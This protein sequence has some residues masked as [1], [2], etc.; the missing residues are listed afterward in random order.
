MDG[1]KRFQ[2]VV[3]WVMAGCFLL[4][5]S[6]V[7][8][9]QQTAG[10]EASKDRTAQADSKKQPKKSHQ[11]GDPFSAEG[12]RKADSGEGMFSGLLKLG[13]QISSALPGQDDQ[14][15]SEKPSK[16]AG[17]SRSDPFSG[18]GGGAGVFSGL[19]KIGDRLSSAG[20]P[21]DSKKEERTILAHKGAPKKPDTG[22]APD[23]PSAEETVQ[24]SDFKIEETVA[25]SDIHYYLPLYTEVTSCL[26]RGQ[27]TAA[28]AVLSEGSADFKDRNRLLFLLENG[29]V[30]LYAAQYGASLQA[31]TE[32]ER[33]DEELYTKS[34]SLQATTF[35]VN[36]L[37][38]PYRGEDYESVMINLFLALA[39]L[40]EKNLD[41]AL[42]EARKVDS[43]LSAI[44]ASYPEDRK[45]AYREDA[46]VR[47]LMGILYQSDPTS[48]NLNDAFVSYRKALEIYE[49][50][51]AKN[52]GTPV[53]ELLKKQVL[54][55]SEWA[56]ESELAEARKRVG[57]LPYV[58][59]KEAEKQA[60][61]T[62]IHFNGKS[63]S[64]VERS[65]VCPLPDGHIIKVA[66]PKYVN[67]LY[68]VDRAR[69]TAH[70]VG[71]KQTLTSDTELGEP[72]AHI[73][74]LNLENRKG[75]IMTKAITRAMAK[76][77]ATKV[78]Q[79][80][81]EQAWG[82]M[83]GLLV[84]ALGDAYIII[85]EQADLRGW[86]TLPA[87]IRLTQLHL[88]PGTYGLEA[89]CYDKKGSQVEKVPLG[90][91]TLKQ[92]EKRFFFVSTTL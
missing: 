90:T 5:M 9:Q 11:R 92:G 23:S 72:I 58:S 69:I 66:F 44:N 38:A 8:T 43:K 48:A 45:N 68:R 73:A 53:P 59:L 20:S 71:R 46:F 63:P 76:Y 85:S 15:A 91:V 16:R 36:D 34:L 57:S 52:Y 2:S 6:C 56:G 17:A 26:D 12:A 88:P 1:F 35:I 50:D 60:T 25:S 33:L 24:L 80:Q 64:K 39:Y 86:V 65:I 41:G 77:A 42:V 3:A 61:V 82:Y 30:N 78:A 67:R 62:V 7:T 18:E 74:H 40:Q 4:V 87:E 49:K 81:A 54:A 47:W 10:T 14:K 32:A 19:K 75:R 84:K 13:T 89:K 22:K 79:Q 51:Y 31:L 29:L 55:L 21:G 28:A 27:F 37:T 70:A 83:A